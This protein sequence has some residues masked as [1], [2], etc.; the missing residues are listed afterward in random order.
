M[1]DRN[2][3]MSCKTQEEFENEMRKI[4]AR[5]DATMLTYR[6]AMDD[7][8]VR[9][10]EIGC[11]ITAAKAEVQRLKFEFQNLLEATAGMTKAEKRAT[12]PERLRIQTMLARAKRV[13]LERQAKLRETET[14]RLRVEIA[15]KEAWVGYNDLK[16][17]LIVANP[18]PLE[19]CGEAQGTVAGSCGEAQGTV[20]GSCGKAQGTVAGD[21]ELKF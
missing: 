6:R 7:L 1:K 11:S 2:G 15:Q 20:A 4:N 19:P 8:K 9:I 5:C 14:S 17:A 3:T 16:H 13:V 10:H 18:K 21:C 12:L